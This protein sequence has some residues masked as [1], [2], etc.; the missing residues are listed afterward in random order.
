[1]GKKEHRRKRKSPH[2]SGHL[3]GGL[4]QEV[5]RHQRL[6]YL[7]ANSKS[8]LKACGAVE[9]MLYLLDRTRVDPET[10]DDLMHLFETRSVRLSAPEVLLKSE[11]LNDMVVPMAVGLNIDGPEKALH[12]FEHMV[13]VA[14]CFCPGVDRWEPFRLGI[15]EHMF[16][17]LAFD[18][19]TDDAF[20][21]KALRYLSAMVDRAE[22]SDVPALDLFTAREKECLLEFHN[23]QDE[24]TRQRMMTCCVASGFHFQLV[25]YIALMPSELKAHLLQRHSAARV[26]SLRLLAN[27]A[28]CGGRSVMRVEGVVTRFEFTRHMQ[29]AGYGSLIES[30]GRHGRTLCSDQPF[31]QASFAQ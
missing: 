5:D 6:H 17:V 16:S 8:I 1:M 25:R 7:L 21:V 14:T 9:F 12:H 19:Q 15:A 28:L 13:H 10:L 11:L 3:H 20:G 24:E 30:S 27:R 18:L 29:L 31:R 23:L 4:P 22:V 26:E 2:P